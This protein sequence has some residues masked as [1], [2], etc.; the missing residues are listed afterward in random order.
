MQVGV[1]QYAASNYPTQIAPPAAPPVGGISPQIAA[2]RQR[3][4]QNGTLTNGT[5]GTTQMTAQQPGNAPMA[6]SNPYGLPAPGQQQQQ[7]LT[8]AQ[9]AILSYVQQNGNVGGLGAVNPAQAQTQANNGL[10]N[11]LQVMQGQ[12]P[13]T[14]PTPIQGGTT[15]SLPQQQMPAQPAMQPLGSGQPTGALSQGAQGLARYYQMR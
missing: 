1:P 10:A 2:L 15:P 14:Q 13:P 5:N 11:N 4:I 8:N 12:M 6:G 9:Q 3:M 7:P